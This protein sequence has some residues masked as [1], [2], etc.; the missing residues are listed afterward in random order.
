MFKFNAIIGVFFL[1]KYFKSLINATHRKDIYLLSI[2]LQD[3]CLNQLEAF[4]IT[5]FNLEQ[6][7]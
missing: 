5:E 1:I 7:R 4:T 2:N 3:N 6:I